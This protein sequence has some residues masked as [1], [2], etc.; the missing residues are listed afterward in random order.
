[1]KTVFALA[2]ALS[3]STV[4]PAAAEDLEFLLVNATGVDIT[5]F[6]V[7]HTETDMWEENLLAGGYLADGY[8]IDVL[9][10]D[11]LT[12]CVYDIRTEFSDGDV[13]EDYG[14]DLCSLG[15]YT[16]E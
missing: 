4:A 5:A 13:Y 3:L 9:I 10:A 15:S 14:V 11:G 8:E 16:F 7:S 12:T 1:M 6:H 2:A